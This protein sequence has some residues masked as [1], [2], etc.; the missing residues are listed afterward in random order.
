M[1]I[2]L[3]VFSK[4]RPHVHGQ[5]VE[6]SGDAPLAC[7]GQRPFSFLGKAGGRVTLTPAV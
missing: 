6:A 5:L 2:P 1:A 3:N 7:H 4:V